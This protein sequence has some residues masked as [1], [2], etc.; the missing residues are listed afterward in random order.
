MASFSTSFAV[1]ALVWTVGARW[2]RRFSAARAF[3]FGAKLGELGVVLCVPAIFAFVRVGILAFTLAIVVFAARILPALIL[4]ILGVGVCV[5]YFGRLF[6][7]G[8]DLD[9]ALVRNGIFLNLGQSCD[10]GLH[11]YLNQFPIP[12]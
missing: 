8:I 5:A 3:A 4:P 12:T 9:D 1:A 11:Q 2:V 7:Y 10:V 6:V